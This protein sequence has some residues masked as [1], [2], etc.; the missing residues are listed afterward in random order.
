M[1]TEIRVQALQEMQIDAFLTS[2]NG[3][4]HGSICNHKIID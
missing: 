3:G 4:S 2:K 1:K